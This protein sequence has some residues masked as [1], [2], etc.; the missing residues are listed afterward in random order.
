MDGCEHKCLFV[1]MLVLE[2]GSAALEGQ[3]SL[4]LGRRLVPSCVRRMD[5][6]SGVTRGGIWGVQTPPRVEIPKAL[7]NR[8]KP[9]PTVKTVKNS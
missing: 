5:A 8:S 7:Q 2:R 6:S 9:N 1:W 4:I 3:T